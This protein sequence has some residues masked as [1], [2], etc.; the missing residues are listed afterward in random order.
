[1]A[2][3]DGIYFG[4]AR[5]PIPDWRTV[6]AAPPSPE[7][8]SAIVGFP[9][10]DLDHPADT[11]S[12]LVR[13]ARKIATPFDLAASFESA[14]GMPDYL[15]PELVAQA[16]RQAHQ[17]AAGAAIEH[18]E[19]AP[20]LQRLARGALRYARK[21]QRQSKEPAALPADPP[22]APLEA[23][24]HTNG[25]PIRRWRDARGIYSQ[26]DP[27]HAGCKQLPN[28]PKGGHRW[29]C[30]DAG[31]GG[32]PEEATPQMPTGDLE[33]IAQ[34]QQMIAMIREAATVKGVATLGAFLGQM[35]P[36][37][38]A[39]LQQA[40]QVQAD[41]GSAAVL[42]AAT[43]RLQQRDVWVGKSVEAG[44]NPEQVIVLAHDLRTAYNVATNT[45]IPFGMSMQVAV[46]Q[47]LESANG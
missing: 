10:A 38:L 14:A 19:E 24:G 26:P 34:A 45:R 39:G 47:L 33:L 18:P 27:P 43:K 5:T 21:Y 44:V 17:I 4:F 32:A 7:V 30:G 1:M 29:D 46:D 40:A 41:V 22:L 42:N 2:D 16:W 3:I 15:P 9:I 23:N 13:R 20:A 8:V 37:D 11:P 35:S 25:K 28:G 6:D 36:E 12:I 31:G